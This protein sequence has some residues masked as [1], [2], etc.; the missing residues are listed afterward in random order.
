MSLVQN[1]VHLV[2]PDIGPGRLL[3]I[4]HTEESRVHVVNVAAGDDEPFS[5]NADNVMLLRWEPADDPWVALRARHDDDITPLNI[6]RRDRAHEAIQNL[7]VL[8]SEDKPAC[9]H[10]LRLLDTK[11]RFRLIMAEANKL[12]LANNMVRRW[13]KRWWVRGMSKNALLP[14]V[15]TMSGAGK[16]RALPDVAC[17]SRG[18]PLDPNLHGKPGRRSGNGRRSGTR[19][20]AAVRASI[21]TLGRKLYFDH[22][23]NSV[24]DTYVLWKEAKKDIAPHRYPAPQ[25][26]YSV[27][28][29]DPAVHAEIKKRALVG[30]K[31][32]G[33]AAESDAM[34]SRM[35]GPGFCYQGDSTPLP[36][37]RVDGKIVTLYFSSDTFTGAIAGYHAYP[38]RPSADAHSRCL[39]H[40]ASDKPSYCAEYNIPISKAHWSMDIVPDTWVA[41]R[42]EL[43][44]PIADYMVSSLGLVLHNTPAYSP[45]LKA[46]VEAAFGALLR[47]LISK[48]D[49]HVAP[50]PGRRFEETIELTLHELHVLI[51]LFIL[52]Y[53]SRKLT[54][55]PTPSQMARKVHMSP[56]GLWN[57]E[58]DRLHGEGRKFSPHELLLVTSKRDKAKLDEAGVNF[59]GLTYS[60]L[61]A[62]AS[63]FQSTLGSRVKDIQIHYDEDHTDRIFIQRKVLK[64]LGV[65]TVEPQHEFIKCVL[66]QRD[67]HWAGYTFPDFLAAYEQHTKDTQAVF[68]IED[69]TKGGAAQALADFN[70]GKM[71]VPETDISG[72]DHG[73]QS[74]PDHVTAASPAPAT[75]PEP[76]PPPASSEESGQEPPK[77]RIPAGLRRS[78]AK[79]NDKSA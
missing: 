36:R 2:G 46:D 5:I 42:G 49:D 50:R 68:D 9:H 75:T 37:V 48:L 59:R 51:I 76:T 78:R 57:G 1:S 60:C 27:L 15:I 73:G 11:H 24:A 69:A 65:A 44:G 54:R 56:L 64:R 21:V 25:A 47:N 31:P 74:K 67:A 18:N 62:G 72:D 79:R 43:I 7:L 66:S 55:V 4:L 16:T 38:G 35:P 41:D 70:A 13:L 45:Q 53:N 6:G 28:V 32:R 77:A 14:D 63:E 19:M 12:K 8:A 17:D 33:G 52:A 3:R 58:V 30:R 23:R 40:A 34:H 71:A 20:T 22:P 10:H 61:E 39:A 29:N 26:F